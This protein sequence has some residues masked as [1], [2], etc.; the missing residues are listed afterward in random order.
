[1]L[2][3]LYGVLLLTLLI[4]ALVSSCENNTVQAVDTPEATAP[5]AAET[6]TLPNTI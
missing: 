5:V 1:M 4:L 6:T 3:R 2:N